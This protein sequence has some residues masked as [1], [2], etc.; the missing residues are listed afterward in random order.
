MR[1]GIVATRPTLTNARLA[2]AG[3]PDWHV[4][5]PERAVEQLRPGDVAIG[6]LD[7]CSTLDGVDGGLAVLGELEAR[8]VRVLNPAGALLAA[9]DKLV[10][11]RLLQGAGLSHP[12][13]IVVSPGERPRW[14]G[15]A[16]VKP[17]FGSWGREVERCADPDALCAHVTS[18]HGKQ[19]FDEQGA[20]VQELVRPRGYD[21]RLIVAA[22]RVVGAARRIAAPGEW[23]TNVA[24][25]GRRERVDPPAAA[26]VL[27]LAAANAAGADLVGVDLLPT[28]DDWTIVE[29]NGAVDFTGLYSLD[30][31]VFAAVT[32]ELALAAVGSTEAGSQPQIVAD[33]G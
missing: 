12:N 6:R 15:T 29:L 9:H 18:L 5:T 33:A 25:G 1:F 21:L 17:R 13:T 22:G 3:G 2:V 32:A 24:L 7:V 31:D 16:V 19:W 30:R 27:A 23:R 14:V 20:I 11:A 28:D 4:L 26:C 10:T 8:G